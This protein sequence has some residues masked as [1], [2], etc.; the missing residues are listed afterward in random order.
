M[1][2]FQSYL[3]SSCP[4]KTSSFYSYLSEYFCTFIIF[5]VSSLK[6]FFT[7][8]I[9][10]IVYISLTTFFSLYESIIFYTLYNTLSFKEIY[11][12]VILL[13]RFSGST[14]KKQAA[15][16]FCHMWKLISSV[17]VIKILDSAIYFSSS[18]KIK[19]YL[20]FCIT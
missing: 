15:E 14:W 5:S 1:L 16:S 3:M 6:N 13:A 7:K 20:Q 4:L 18:L 2:E 10:C 17:N 9:G 8:V 11:L 19:D 12:V